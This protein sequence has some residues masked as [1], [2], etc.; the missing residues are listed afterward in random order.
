MPGGGEVGGQPTRPVRA[1]PLRP[2]WHLHARPDQ[3]PPAPSLSLSSH[4]LQLPASLRRR[5]LMYYACYLI[6]LAVFC[7]LLT[8]SLPPVLGV[9][10]SS[11]TL[12][13][14]RICT[15]SMNLMALVATLRLLRIARRSFESGRWPSSC[16][17]ISLS[18]LHIRRT[19]RTV[20]RP[21]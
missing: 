21:S 5:W 6:D 2:A 13:C 17:R 19:C 16:L 8:Y 4:R 1:A 9:V 7:R 14:P 3:L 12:L 10:Y 11:A 18:L 20:W 15:R